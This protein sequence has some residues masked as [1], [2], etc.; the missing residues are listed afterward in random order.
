MLGPTMSKW[1]PDVYLMQVA[2]NQLGFSP[3]EIDGI[4]GK[5]TRGARE[6]W[7]LSRKVNIEVE[8]SPSVLVP[9]SDYSSMVSFYGHPGDEGNLQRIALPYAMRL[10]WDKSVRVT[11]TRVHKKI[12]K[13]LVQALTDLLNHYGHEG[14]RKHGLD[15]F[16]GV[17]NNRNTRG[18]RKKSTHAWGAAIDLNPAENGNRLPWYA[19]KVGQKGFGTMP[20]EAVEIFEARGFKHGG[21]AWGR[22]AMHFQ[23]TK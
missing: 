7:L 20:V 5:M 14:L 6:R 21:R 17:Y 1:D 18:G 10:A 3:G 2:L 19:N 11:S 13:P 15:L 16:G 8:A 22:D 9:A 12:A 23:Y 4:D